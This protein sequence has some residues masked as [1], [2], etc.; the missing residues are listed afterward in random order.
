MVAFSLSSIRLQCI[1]DLIHEDHNKIGK[2]FKKLRMVCS[3]F[4][5]GIIYEL[6]CFKYSING[7][8]YFT[9]VAPVS[10]GLKAFSP[11]FFLLSPRKA[12]APLPQRFVKVDKTACH[13]A[14]ISC[15]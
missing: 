9:K 6:F 3:D 7:G 8:I 2:V 5:E 11:D 14:L 15:D 10:C 13:D 4:S 12:P 1:I